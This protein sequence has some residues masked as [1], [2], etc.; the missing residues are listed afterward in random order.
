MSLKVHMLLR[1]NRDERE[2]VTLCGEPLF[3]VV[4]R[5][6]CDD[7]YAAQRRIGGIVAVPERRFEPVKGACRKCVDRWVKG[8][9]LR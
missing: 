2:G 5:T 9:D 7:E 4:S 8:A 6:Y 1:Y 3:R